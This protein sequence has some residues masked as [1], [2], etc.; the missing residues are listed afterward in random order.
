MLPVD[1]DVEVAV[2][3]LMM[4]RWDLG[5]VLDET[6]WKQPGGF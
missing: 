2:T 4:R 1:T 6:M 5:Q 3:P